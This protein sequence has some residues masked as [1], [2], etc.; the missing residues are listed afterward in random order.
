MVS[1]DNNIVII[2]LEQEVKRNA[3]L[4]DFVD[5]KILID[6]GVKHHLPA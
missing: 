4:L 6:P 5:E 2:E 1:L 3:Y